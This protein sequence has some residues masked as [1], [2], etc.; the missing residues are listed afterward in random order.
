M[1]KRHLEAWITKFNNII[2]TYTGVHEIIGYHRDIDNSGRG[3]WYIDIECGNCGDKVCMR[4]DAFLV[5]DKYCDNCSR[6]KGHNTK[7]GR[8]TE[9]LNAVYRTMKAK[10]YNTNDQNYYKYGAKGITICD[11]W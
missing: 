7:D 1:Q 5:A 3:R 2:D 10:C 9:A 8:S 6:A 4:D 11:E